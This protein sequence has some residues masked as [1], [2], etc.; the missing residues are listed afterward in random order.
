MVIVS[1]LIWRD[2]VC[3]H[4]SFSQNIQHELLLDFL[5]NIRIQRFQKVNTVRLFFDIP[6]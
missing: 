2:M 4:L 3:L 1:G 5:N 6:H